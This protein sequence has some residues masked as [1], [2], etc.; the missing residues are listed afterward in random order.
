MKKFLTILAVSVLGVFVVA[1]SAMA[2]PINPVGGGGSEFSLQEILDDITVN[3]MGDSSIDVNTDQIADESDSLWSITGSGGSVATFIIEISAYA[4]SN[5]W[6]IYDPSDPTN[7]VE[8]FAGGNTA[9]DQV[10]LSIL[11][12]GSV[13]TNGMDTGVDLANDVF[14]F[15]LNSPDGTFYSETG[16]NADQADHMV[17]FQ[18]NDLDKIQLPGYA[19]GTWTDNEYLFAWED[20]SGLGDWDYNDLVVMV[21]SIEPIPE[22]GTVLLLGAGLIGLIGLGRKFK[23]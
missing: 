11:A 6:G 13:K 14:G 18:G 1:G 8:I 15:Y 23:K 17:A 19:P 3:P 21:E 9:G 7:S 12:D 4:D 5:S 2:I 16:L 10:L 20:V 22:P